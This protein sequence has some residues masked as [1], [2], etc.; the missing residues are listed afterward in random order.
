MSDQTHG[1]GGTPPTEPRASTS[2]DPGRRTA[3]LPPMQRVAGGHEAVTRRG[4]V[5]VC[6]GPSCT[7]RGSVELFERLGALPDASRLLLCKTTCLDH[8][9]TGPNIVIT[10]EE[11][12]QTGVQ[13]GQ[14]DELA[15]LLLPNPPPP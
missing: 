2:S 14:V 3:R 13:P 9:A 1:P 8:C 4:L 10:D 11:R 5:M 15:R 7:E 6:H 12:I